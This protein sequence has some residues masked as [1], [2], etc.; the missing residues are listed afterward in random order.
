[1]HPGRGHGHGV[2][3]VTIRE[4][5]GLR[6]QLT[7]ACRVQRDRVI[8]D[9]VANEAHA[10]LLDL[11]DRVGTVA[12]TKKHLAGV[13]SANLRQETKPIREPFEDGH[14]APVDQTT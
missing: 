5:R 9:D 6:E 1:M 2:A 3:V 11:E 14:G 8:V 4:Q 13:E 12:L 7:Q 10:P